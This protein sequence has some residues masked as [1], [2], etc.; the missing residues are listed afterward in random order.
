MKILYL[1]CFFNYTCVISYYVNYF[2][3]VKFCSLMY[4]VENLSLNPYFNIAAEE[5]LVK[6]RNEDLFS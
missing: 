2:L 1:I 6:N 4:L 3:F 5:Y